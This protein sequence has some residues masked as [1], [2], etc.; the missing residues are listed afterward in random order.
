MTGSEV[1]TINCR[2]L[3]ISSNRI[4]RLGVGPLC[5]AVTLPSSYHCDAE[6]GV[7]GPLQVAYF[8]IKLQQGT[9][10]NSLAKLISKP[11]SAYTPQKKIHWRLLGT[12]MNST[13]MASCLLLQLLIGTNINS[14]A[15]YG[16]IILLFAIVALVGSILVLAPQS[17]GDRQNKINS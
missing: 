3:L 2:N 14:F 8:S 10:P 5:S 13:G 11:D 15:T 6:M 7:G 12:L 4:S 17:F 16:W 9:L 1:V